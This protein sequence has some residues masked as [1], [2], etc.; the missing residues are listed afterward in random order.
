MDNPKTFLYDQRD[1]IATITLNRPE[2]LNTFHDG[3]LANWAAAL[4]DCQADD[5]IN[6]VIPEKDDSFASIQRRR[7]RDHRAAR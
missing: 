1:R 7:A 4:R 3:M 5:A 2:Q 6:V